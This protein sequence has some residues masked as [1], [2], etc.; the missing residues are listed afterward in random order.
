M[1][2]IFSTLPSQGGGFVPP[3]RVPAQKKTGGVYGRIHD[4]SATI[5]F[6]PWKHPTNF[7]PGE[8]KLKG[9]QRNV[10]MCDE[11]ELLKKSIKADDTRRVRESTFPSCWNSV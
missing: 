6:P 5:F 8:K 2:L 3:H 7:P 4:R 10:E 11:L 1:S 9:R